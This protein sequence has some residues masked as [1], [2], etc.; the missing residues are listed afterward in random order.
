MLC[1]GSLLSVYGYR[2]VYPVYGMK[3]INDD[4]KCFVINGLVDLYSEFYQDLDGDA[5]I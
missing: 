1:C 2:W 4:I 3:L 5:S